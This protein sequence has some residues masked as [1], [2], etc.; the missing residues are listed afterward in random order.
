MAAR[1]KRETIRRGI[2]S[3]EIGLR[4]IDA[5]RQASGPQTL[6]EL[7]QSSD[8][9]PSNCHR[10]LVSFVRAGFVSQDPGTARYDLG[11]QLLQAGLAALSRLD[12]VAIGTDALTRLVDLSGH[13]GLLAIWADLGAVIVRWMPGR[14]AVR[15][16]L[17][18]GSML[19]LLNSATGRIFL[20]Y[21]PKRQTQRL[22]ALETP[23]RNRDV[24]ALA[25]SVRA[26][27]MAQVSGDHIPGLSAISAPVLDAHGEAAAAITLVG[28]SSG[29]APDTIAALRSTARDA[30]SALGWSNPVA[31]LVARERVR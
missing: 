29:F 27:G 26:N 6:K 2:Q 11:P 5:L 1:K 3:V 24:E 21:L 20:A 23:A 8:V 30:S 12:V 17:S 22:V 16:T 15:T 14:L 18:T 19:P 25:A 10:Y 31:G 28:L 9:P 7:A 4:V 13:T